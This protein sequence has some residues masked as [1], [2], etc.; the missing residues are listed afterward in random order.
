M[1]S[2]N[3]EAELYARECERLAHLSANPA[4]RERFFQM[5]RDWRAVATGEAQ[6]PQPRSSLGK[7]NLDSPPE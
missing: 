2:S 1:A 7:R 6:A 5:S 4:M 3:D